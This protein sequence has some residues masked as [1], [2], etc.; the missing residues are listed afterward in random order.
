M[1]HYAGNP[2]TRSQQLLYNSFLLV[3]NPRNSPSSNSSANSHA[4]V[5][6]AIQPRQPYLL[7]T[8]ATRFRVSGAL[9]SQTPPGESCSLIQFSGP[10]EHRAKSS[11]AS[12]TESTSN[13]SA[14]GAF[15]LTPVSSP[16]CIC[17][18]LG[19]NRSNLTTIN[20]NSNESLPPSP[21]EHVPPLHSCKM[22]GV[23]L[24]NVQ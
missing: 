8:T 14:I 3:R 20:L 16:F 5:L 12:A 21:I 11:T 24:R 13:N 1:Q 17:P 22:T 10:Q 18:Y 23:C 19:R 9:C 7:L 6:Q 4:I 15:L 2:S